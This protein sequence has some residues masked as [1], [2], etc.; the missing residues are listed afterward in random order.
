MIR[1]G[2]ITSPQPKTLRGFLASASDLLFSLDSKL[3]RTLIG[4]VR[5]PV[6]TNRIYLSEAGDLLH[7]LKLLIGLSS[8]SV[9]V[10]ALLP[11]APHFM[12]TLTEVH[13]E[14]TDELRQSIESDGATWPHFVDVANQR[15]ILLNVPFVMLISLPIMLYFKLLKRSRP[16]LD[17]A[18]LTLNAFN[19]YLIFHILSAPLYALPLSLMLI[20]GLPLLLVLIPYLVLILLRFYARSRWHGICSTLGLL[21]VFTV[22]YLIASNATVFVAIAW[23]AQSVVSG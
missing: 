22:S 15:A 3:W 16:A 10:W 5:H 9:V 7:P 11:W 12:D 14:I 2:Q 8:I 19:V 6:E 23:A 21:F 18:I 20:S 17:H 4:L 13:P 1:R